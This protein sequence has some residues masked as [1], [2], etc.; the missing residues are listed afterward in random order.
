MATPAG[1]SANPV[2]PRECERQS[3]SLQ[4]S[5]A[6]TAYFF[7]AVH[8]LQ[9]RHYDTGIFM[10][11]RVELSLALVCGNAF[12]SAHVL[13]QVCGERFSSRS[14]CFISSTVGLPPLFGRSPSCVL[15]FSLLSSR[16]RRF[17]LIGTPPTRVICLSR[18][19]AP[20]S[21]SLRFVACSRQVS[22]V[23]AI[24]R[25]KPLGTCW[26][27]CSVNQCQFVARGPYKF[28]VFFTV[29]ST[30]AGIR[31]RFRRLLLMRFCPLRTPHERQ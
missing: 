23:L 12:R 17:L 21:R 9:F 11:L 7:N 19:R 5:W 22:S 4:T 1:V 8:H 18:A 3:T 10:P 15:A 13:F 14:C 31:I 25:S 28:G 2:W 20:P 24:S 30:M 29:I 6:R 26:G 16:H 27:L